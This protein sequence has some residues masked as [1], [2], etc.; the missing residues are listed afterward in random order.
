MV[1]GSPFISK[2]NHQQEMCLGISP[3]TGMCY[4]GPLSPPLR[5]DVKKID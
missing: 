5:S 4:A 3:L 1:H 2:K